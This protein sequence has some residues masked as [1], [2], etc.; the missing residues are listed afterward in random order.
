[1]NPACRHLSHMVV[2]SSSSETQGQLVGAGG[3]ISGKEMKRRRFHSNSKK[4]TLRRT[5][6]TFGSRFCSC[7]HTKTVPIYIRMFVINSQ[8]TLHTSSVFDC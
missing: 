2:I 6:F 7:S 8:A 4:Q 1:M 5:A 3:N